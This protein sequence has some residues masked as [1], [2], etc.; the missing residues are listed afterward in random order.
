[1]SL[2]MKSHCTSCRYRPGC[3]TLYRFDSFK[4]SYSVV[5]V[6]SYTVN[7]KYFIGLS[8]CALHGKT[9]PLQKSFSFSLFLLSV[10]ALTDQRMTCSNS[11]RHW[12][13]TALRLYSSFEGVIKILVVNRYSLPLTILNVSGSISTLFHL[14]LPSIAHQPPYG[15]Y[16]M[17]AAL[18]VSPVLRS[19]K[20]I[21]NPF[22]RWCWSLFC[23][24]LYCRWSRQQGRSLH[25]KPGFHFRG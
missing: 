8:V 2:Q 7:G 21:R 18:K 14:W 10:K 19:R 5:S 25:G 12:Y 20:I 22:K 13:L 9:V 15:S 23:P 24:L 6:N 16:F 1:M 3:R 17:G 4:E 11:G